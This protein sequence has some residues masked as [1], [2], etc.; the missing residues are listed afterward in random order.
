MQA[1]VI[2]PVWNGETIIAECLEAIYR[3]ATASLKEVFCVDNASV[4][5]SAT[6]IAEQFPQVRLLPQPVN[7]G[8]AGGVN[9]G[10]R[11]ATGDVFVLLN[12]DCIVQEKW[13]TPLIDA[14]SNH[15]QY[16]I[17][18]GTIFEADG[19]INHTGAR[20]RRPDAY[21]IH[22]TATFPDNSPREVDYVTG[23][24][25]A[26][27]R[28]AWDTIGPFDEAFYPAYFEEVDYCYRARHHGFQV[29]HVPGA[30]ATHRFTSREW[31]KEPLRHA[32]N[33]HRARYR[34][35]SKHFTTEQ[36]VDFFSAES[37]AIP[38][39][40]YRDQVLGRLLAA[41]D[42]LHDLP[43]ILAARQSDL[44]KD[45]DPI[46]QRLLQVNFSHVQNDALSAA[47]N[48]MADRISAS[49]QQIAELQEEKD[50]LLADIYFRDPHEPE[51]ESGWQRWRM[52]LLRLVSI[53]TLREHRLLVRLST[54]HVAQFAQLQDHLQLLEQD[55][56][57][58]SN[59]LRTL[60]T[61]EYG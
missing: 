9:R 15:P 7:L 49:R 43:A 48:E 6:I 10:M 5:R 12:Q 57:N 4:D 46:R 30:R 23:A 1:S 16:G 18:G 37:A 40:I 33:Q 45:A 39:Q 42:V 38:A 55:A 24:M 60:A 3:Y 58:H 56:R 53:F 20:L 61:N 52:I 11:S 54:L 31:Q 41:R 17:L 32:T 35:V 25:L 36:L 50:T 47:Q 51:P 27:R 19:S 59:L 22:E 8:F 44:E 29:M 26:I 2:I 21:G 13:L 14:F 28:S 34:F